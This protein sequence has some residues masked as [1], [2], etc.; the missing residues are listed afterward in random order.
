MP[1]RRVVEPFNVVKHIGAC[2]LSG[3]I[4]LPGCAFGLERT[5]EALNGRV[6]PDLASPA[7]AACS[8]LFLEQLLEVLTGVLA[9]LVRVVE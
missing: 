7:H 8:A 3:S 6:I 2:L 5:E 1:T 4:D 9:T